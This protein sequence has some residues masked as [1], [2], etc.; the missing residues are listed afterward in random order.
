MAKLNQNKPPKN[1]NNNN[2]EK[3]AI[4]K[5]KLATKHAYNI[6][7]QKTGKRIKNERRYLYDS[8]N[9]FS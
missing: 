2:N 5:H 6:I 9:P 4:E 7:N 8:I 1:D 3:K